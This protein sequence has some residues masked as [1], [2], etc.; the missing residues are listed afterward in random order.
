MTTSNSY[1]DTG[2]V[3]GCTSARQPIPVDPSRSEATTQPPAVRPRP[4][5]TPRQV[6]H[7]PLV[8]RVGANPR[9]AGARR[10]ARPT[11]PPGPPAARQG[12][13]HRPRGPWG[14][15]RPGPSGPPDSRSFSWSSGGCTSPW[16]S[17]LTWI[18]MPRIKATLRRMSCSWRMPGWT[19]G[20]SEARQRESRRQAR[21]PLPRPDTGGYP[22][23]RAPGTGHGSF[24]TAVTFIGVTGLISGVRL[25]SVSSAGCTVCSAPCRHPLS[26]CV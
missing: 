20:P 3:L 10:S 8:G 26:P 24:P 4:P 15:G 11:V 9:E 18:S 13:P 19:S 22:N 1:S 7:G 17:T 25:H 16:N 12:R 2:C 5:Q 21:R 23:S 6:A 14:S